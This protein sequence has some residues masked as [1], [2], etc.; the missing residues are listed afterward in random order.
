MAEEL[1]LV[2]NFTPTVKAAQDLRTWQ[3][4]AVRFD[5]GGV[6]PAT[7]N[8]ESGQ[9]YV[10]GNKPNSGHACE[11]VSRTNHTKASAG[12][13]ILAG[14]II[15]FTSSQVFVATSGNFAGDSNA[16]LVMG[17]AITGCLSGS[18]FT[19]SVK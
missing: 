1:T 2:P 5:S 14:Q 17:T 7:T 19:L 13:T 10:L 4:K 9:A 3:Y 12:G 18:I 11:L 8:I 6:R 16:I 15:T